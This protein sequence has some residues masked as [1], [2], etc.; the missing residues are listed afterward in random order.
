MFSDPTLL[1][2]LVLAL[3][4]IWG[5]LFI[6]FVK[7]R[8]ITF[9]S[10][11]VL[12]FVIG[13]LALG[14]GFSIRIPYQHDKMEI[15]VYTV[16]YDRVHALAHPLKVPSEPM[17]IVFSIDPNNPAGAQMRKSFFDAVR[18]REEEFHKTSLVL[19]M[20][21][22]MVDMGEYKYEVASTLPPKIQ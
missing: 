4:V 20:R 5:M 11:V 18:K 13:Y 17:H 14:T 12:F 7:R 10:G 6:I 21:G 19:D 1:K 8:L 15:I 2:Y 16:F 22:F 3:V 9:L